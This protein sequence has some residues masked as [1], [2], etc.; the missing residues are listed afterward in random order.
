MVVI[1][2]FIREFPRYKQMAE[3]GKVVELVDRQG[4]R[5]TFA[6]EKPKRS[7]GS[8]R[9]M[10]K[11]KPLSPEPISPDEWGSPY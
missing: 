6:A 10:A 9:H 8:A 4:K 11:G 1:R 2:K 3:A 5:F 7:M